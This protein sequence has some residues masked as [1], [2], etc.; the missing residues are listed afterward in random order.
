MLSLPIQ[1]LVLHPRIARQSTF[2]KQVFFAATP[3]YEE[4]AAKVHSNV[5]A[6]RMYMHERGLS[7]GVV[8]PA[9]RRVRILGEL[10]YLTDPGQVEY[11]V[12]AVNV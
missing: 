5:R 4:T 11:W 8:K 2:R 1:C 12:V 10:A 6:L 3:A 7:E 9:G